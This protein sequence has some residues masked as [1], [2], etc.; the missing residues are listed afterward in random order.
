MVL[1]APSEGAAPTACAV[2]RDLPELEGCWLDGFAAPVGDPWRAY[3]TALSAKA[4]ECARERGF[5]CLSTD[6]FE[7]GS[8]TT[9]TLTALGFGAPAERERTWRVRL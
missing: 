8:A 9:E 5:R 1:A 3:V 2:V 7:F 6:V 4:I